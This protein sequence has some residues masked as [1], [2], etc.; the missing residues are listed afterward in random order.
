MADLEAK[1]ERL[2][3]ALAG[4]L[5]GWSGPAHANPYGPWYVPP[6]PLQGPHT[7]HNRRLV[8]EALGPSA[9]F[10]EGNRDA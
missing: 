10:Y 3:K 2:H 6:G 7:A 9:K 1:A 4:L 8:A 5:A